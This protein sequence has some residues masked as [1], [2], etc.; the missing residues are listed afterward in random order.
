LR[1]LVNRILESGEIA[2][3]EQ[4]DRPAVRAL[5]AHPAVQHR[6]AGA[7]LRVGEQVEQDLQLGPVVELA[8]QQL[9]RGRVERPD[10]LLVAEPEELLE[11]ERPTRRVDSR[12]RTLR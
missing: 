7:F 6:R 8:A 9:Q 3:R 2:R 11:A 5:R 12:R 1:E 10:Q 4:V